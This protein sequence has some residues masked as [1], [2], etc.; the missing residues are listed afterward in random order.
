MKQEELLR[1]I[2]LLCELR[3]DMQG[4]SEVGLVAKLDLVIG[5]LEHDMREGTV[6]RET[7]R[8]GLKLMG[9]VLNR[10]PDIA[11]LIQSLFG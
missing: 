7:V 2:E 10:L 4:K 6:D 9:H 5:K 1:T 11:K 3:S 8:E